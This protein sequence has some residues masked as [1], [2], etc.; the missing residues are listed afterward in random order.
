MRYK[1]SYFKIMIK[2]PYRKYHYCKYPYCKYPYYKY[3]YHKYK[4]DY[5]QTSKTCLRSQKLNSNKISVTDESF[6]PLLNRIDECMSY[7]KANVSIPDD[8]SRD[9][10]CSGYF[11]EIIVGRT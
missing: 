6:V 11:R 10:H 1:K 3:P 5:V 2:Y 9:S 8:S 4:Y 7:L